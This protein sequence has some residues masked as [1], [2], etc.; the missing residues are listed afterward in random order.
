MRLNPYTRRTWSRPREL[1]LIP[2]PYTTSVFLK[3]PKDMFDSLT[4]LFEENN[5]NQMKCRNSMILQEID[6]DQYLNKKGL[7]KIGR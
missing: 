5:I 1:L 6:L 2:S 7:E 3:K 4:K